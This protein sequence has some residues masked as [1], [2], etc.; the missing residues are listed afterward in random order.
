MGI[1]VAVF[2]GKVSIYDILVEGVELDGSAAL[3]GE[4]FVDE[5]AAAV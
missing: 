2:G 3:V 5:P 4:Y 1:K